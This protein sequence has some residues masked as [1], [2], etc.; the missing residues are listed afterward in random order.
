[1]ALRKIS[2]NN[3]ENGLEVIK[4]YL[5][6]NGLHW[7]DGGMNIANSSFSDAMHSDERRISINLEMLGIENGELNN[8]IT[9]YIKGYNG[10]TTYYEYVYYVSE[11][12]VPTYIDGIK[13]KTW[14]L[15]KPADEFE[16]LTEA[17]CIFVDLENLGNDVSQSGT[18]EEYDNFNYASYYFSTSN[19]E[20]LTNF[21]EALSNGGSSGGSNGG[22]YVDLLNEVAVAVLEKEGQST[23]KIKGSEIPNRIRALSGGGN[24]LKNLLDLTK[25]AEALFSNCLAEDVSNYIQYDDT[26]N[27]TI[28]YRMFNGCTNLK[29][30]PLINISKVTDCRLMFYNCSSLTS[31]PELDFS[32]ATTINSL[33]Y[34]CNNLREIKLFN[35]YNVTTLGA[36][37]S[38]CYNLEKI[39]FPH[40]N[41]TSTSSNGSMCQDCYSLRAFIIRSFGSS[42]ILNSNTFSNCYHLTGTYHATYNPNSS[43]DGYIY[44]P[45]N[46]ID[47]L[48][49]SSNWSNYATQLRALED[50]TVDGTT[51]GELDESKI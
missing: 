28:S 1:M 45:R 36:C 21:V 49:S 9:V 31:V 13:A 18:L 23:G 34:N 7:I 46:M 22:T 37:F 12:S 30:I 51:T 17:P 39:D 3:I 11:S 24:T 2:L 10:M 20:L 6:D 35:L 33:F 14:Y 32:N 25:T 38:A 27:V 16:E 4:N 40:Y 5:V 29:T 42:Y 50:Y 26:E 43:K 8:Q 48:S 44:V 19:L 15:K 47:T 41:I